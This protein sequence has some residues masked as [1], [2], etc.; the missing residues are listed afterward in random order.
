[1]YDPG[2]LLESPEIFGV[3]SLGFLIKWKNSNQGVSGDSSAL[4]ILARQ[5][6]MH[7]GVF[8]SET[9]SKG[10]HDPAGAPELRVENPRISGARNSKSVK[11]P[12][13][14]R[15]KTPALGRL[16]LRFVGSFRVPV[17]RCFEKQIPKFRVV[18]IQLL[19]TRKKHPKFG[20]VGRVVKSVRYRD[21]LSSP[22]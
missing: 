11:T 12:E 22:G 16:Q 10:F 5:G 6:K 18:K 19:T 9:V 15:P 21:R 20:C 1:M 3:K 4:N 14:R 7:L 13:N 17:F 2:L 8:L